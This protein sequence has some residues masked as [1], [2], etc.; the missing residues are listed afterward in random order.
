MCGVEIILLYPLNTEL[1]INKICKVY[2]SVIQMMS[3]RFESV[4][5][6][7]EKQLKINGYLELLFEQAG[8]ATNK[9]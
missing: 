8:K 4:N 3:T 1:H 6:T 7:C 9:K 5:F 2:F